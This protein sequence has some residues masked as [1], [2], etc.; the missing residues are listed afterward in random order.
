LNKSCPNRIRHDVS[1]NRNQV[2]I[3]SQC[4][5]KITPLPNCAGIVCNNID[6]SGRM[7]LDIVNDAGQRLRTVKLRKPMQMFRHQDKAQ[8][9]CALLFGL[10]PQ[11]VDDYSAELKILKD[12][13]SV[14]RHGSYVIDLSGHC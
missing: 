3:A 11:A 2:F 14:Q 4:M 10:V 12:R 7:R 1:R 8:S 5:I 13:P 9:L 6:S